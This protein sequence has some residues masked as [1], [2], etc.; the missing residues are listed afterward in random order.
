MSHTLLISHPMLSPI[1]AGLEAQGYGVVRRWEMKDGDAQ[2][3]E[4][5]YA[6]P[7]RYDHTKLF[8]RSNWEFA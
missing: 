8:R 7:T 2:A 1:Q 3:V 4:A 5:S 6:D